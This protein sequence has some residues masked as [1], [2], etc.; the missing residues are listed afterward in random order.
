MCKAMSMGVPNEYKVC[1]V[2][3]W[4]LF[5][6]KEHEKVGKLTVYVF[7]DIAKAC[8]AIV[9]EFD[10]SMDALVFT[11]P[12]EQ[13]DA[14]SLDRLA[15]RVPSAMRVACQTCTRPPPVAFAFGRGAGMRLRSIAHPRSGPPPCPTLRRC[16]V[17]ACARPSG[18]QG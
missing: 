12:G 4:K 15:G 18:R 10:V 1:A 8:P 13:T 2:T 16:R 7:R 9:G 6:K 17:T 14:G 5:T 11:V 3:A